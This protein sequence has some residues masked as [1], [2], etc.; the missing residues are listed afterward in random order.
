MWC[1]V[2]CEVKINLKER[3]SLK[4]LIDSI[5]DSL[6]IANYRVAYEHNDNLKSYLVYQGKNISL[7]ECVPLFWLEITDKSYFNPN[8]PIDEIFPKIVNF[9]SNQYRL[10]FEQ[11]NSSMNKRECFT[12]C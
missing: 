10:S 11:L 9:I 7:F 1:R 3:V 4:T 6:S 5:S 8:M 2:R 12:F